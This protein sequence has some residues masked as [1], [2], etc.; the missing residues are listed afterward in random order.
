M[1]FKKCRSLLTVLA[2]IVLFFPSLASAQVI[3]FMD[4]NKLFQDMLEYE[5]FERG[6]PSPDLIKTASYV[7]Y[8]EGVYDA[9]VDSFNAPRNVTLS[10]I[11]SIVAKYLKDNPEKRSVS[12]ADLIADALQKA[13]PKR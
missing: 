6:D 7:G 1:E 8:V 2:A 10:Q 5:K 12:A 3:V 4:G 13:F 11:C 9:M